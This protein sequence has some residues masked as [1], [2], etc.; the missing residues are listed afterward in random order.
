[1]GFDATLEFSAEAIALASRMPEPECGYAVRRKRCG[2][3][4]LV[5]FLKS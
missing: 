3:C 2:G 1:M 5:T 4:R